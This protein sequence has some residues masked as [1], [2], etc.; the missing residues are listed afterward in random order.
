[1][2]S[3]GA[4]EYAEKQ[5]CEMA[6]T[7][8]FKTDKRWESLKR[9]KEKAASLGSLN[10]LSVSDNK[11]GTVGAVALDKEGHITAG[12]STGGMTNKKYNRIGD[13]PI[14]G[15]GTYANDTCNL[16]IMKTTINI[17][18]IKIHFT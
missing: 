15:A 4:E 12:T 9:A 5:G 13:S 2:V 11:F 17:V 14:I 18:K 6:R 10:N 16:K 1:M 3:K 7:S 8:Y